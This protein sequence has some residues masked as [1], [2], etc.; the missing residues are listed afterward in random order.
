MNKLRR[1]TISSDKASNQHIN[2]QKSERK[3]LQQLTVNQNTFKRQTT[4]IN[5]NVPTILLGAAMR[6]SM[7]HRCVG[8]N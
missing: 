5:T 4:F 1:V 8:K 2:K 6:Q 7:R 3:K